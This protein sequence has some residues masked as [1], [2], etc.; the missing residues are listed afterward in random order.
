VLGY[1]EPELLGRPYM[2]FVLPED[3]QRTIDAAS[4]LSQGKEIVHFENRYLHK[5]GTHRWLLWMAAPFPE[6]QTVFAAARDI[7]ER[8]ADEEALAR[9]ARILEAARRD[10]EDQ[11]ARQARLMKELEI[12]KRRAEAATETKSTFLANMSHEIRTPLSVILGMT[13][14]VLDT[15][16]TDRQREQLATVKT[17][18][19]S[20]LEIVN[21][22]LDFSKIEA[23][24]LDLD[25]AVFDLRDVAGDTARLLALRAEEK[26]LELALDIAADVPD[27]VIGDPGRLGQVLLNLIGNAVKFTSTGE[28]VVRVAM[29]SAAADDVTLEFRISDTGIGIPADKRE[30]I[31]QA[32]TQADASTTRRYGGTGLGLAIVQR[33]VELMGGR[34]GVESE[35]GV[36]STFHFTAVFGRVKAEEVPDEPGP[37][38]DGIRVLVV[39]DNATNRQILA[40]MLGS[41]RMVATVVNDAQGAMA[42]LRQAKADERYDAV[43]ADAQ[44]PGIDGVALAARIQKDQQLRGTPVILLTPVGRPVSGASGVH[45]SL[46]K[47][48]KHSD[49][50]D[51]LA[52]ALHGS[53]RRSAGRAASSARRPAARKLRVLVAED[54]AV[55]RKLLTT[56][57]RKRGHEVVEAEHGRAAVDKLAASRAGFDVIVMDLQMP[58][59]GGLE[60]TR[61]IREREASEK[62][63]RVPIVALTAHAL[64]GDRER[65]LAAGMDDY[66]SKPI[67]GEQLVAVVEARAGAAI[68]HRHQ[69]AGRSTDEVFD[70]RAALA[71][72]GGDRTL[73]EEVVSLFRDDCP[74]RVDA[75]ARALAQ[76][77]SEA[78]RMTAHA[79][80]GA[81]A[82]VGAPAVRDIAAA[83]E[84]AARAQRFEE[85]DRIF[86][87]LRDR[88]ARLDDAFVASGLARRAPRRTTHR[89]RSRS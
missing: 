3:R 65:C 37:V 61:V 13:S 38:L 21:D 88:L 43:I 54:H 29:T 59:M 25:R 42:A 67:D 74:A 57:L 77:D 19:E 28:V 2:E 30:H 70:E 23:Q 36:G 47:P 71:H 53:A 79:L 68:P 64:P 66:L 15:R 18:A 27:K 9:Y 63:E 73:L 17:S 82:V 31:F 12:A 8:K 69:A 56:V 16:L 14:L 10:L 26:G 52:G 39:D 32:F 58:E 45:A 89:K 86:A 60:A 11:A 85:A 46:A 5:D 84:E 72:A 87:D 80:K 76:R 83:L 20:L 35:P 48:V 33:L 4:A 44:M 40:Q 6:R 75:L 81:I 22:V 24:R 41:W 51:A 34:I 50:F 62:L 7:T 1:S 78:V 49:L 55:N